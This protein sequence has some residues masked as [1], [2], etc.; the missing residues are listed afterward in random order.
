MNLLKEISFLKVKPL[1]KFNIACVTLKP[2]PPANMTAVNSRI[3]WGTVNDKKYEIVPVDENIPESD[4]TENSENKKDKR[5]EIVYDG[6]NNQYILKNYKDENLVFY[7]EEEKKKYFETL[8]RVYSKPVAGKKFKSKKKKI[9]YIEG[10]FK[11]D[12]DEEIFDSYSK[13]LPSADI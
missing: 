3:P 2:A 10:S 7:T 12:K 5:L 1:N 13:A 6:K 9:R 8:D 4:K 11:N